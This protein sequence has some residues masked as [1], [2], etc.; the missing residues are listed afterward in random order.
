MVSIVGFF[1]LWAGLAAMTL[2]VLMLPAWRPPKW[3]CDETGLPLFPKDSWRPP[4]RIGQLPSADG[5]SDRE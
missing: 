4:S 2:V 5:G 1:G 3:L